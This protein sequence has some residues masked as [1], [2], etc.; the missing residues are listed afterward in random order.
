MERFVLSGSDTN[1]RFKAPWACQKWWVVSPPKLEFLRGVKQ[2]KWLVGGLEHFLFPFH[3]WD[4]PYKSYE[5]SI[6]VDLCKR[7]MWWCHPTWQPR[8]LSLFGRVKPRWSMWGRSKVKSGWIFWVKLMKICV[9]WCWKL[10]QMLIST[11]IFGHLRIHLAGIDEDMSFFG[12][13]LD[14]LW[15][16]K[17]ANPLRK[18]SEPWLSMT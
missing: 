17:A 10:K 15:P 1:K 9:F 13:Y 7:A 4:N 3:I 2:L 6:V 14:H 8:V 11:S 5:I 12:W 18:H 16:P